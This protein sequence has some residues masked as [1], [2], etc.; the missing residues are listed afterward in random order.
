MPQL[1]YQGHA[2]F[3]LTA[4]DGRVIYIDPYV[5]DGYD[6]PAS[7]IVVTH[8]H[9]DHNRVRLCARAA[10]CRVITSR[11]ALANGRHQ[12]FDIAG[13]DLEAVEAKN[14]LHSPKKCVGYIIRLDGVSLYHSGDTSTTAQMAQLASYQ[15]DYALLCGDGKINMGP[16]EAARCARLIGARHNIMMHNQPGHLFNLAKAQRWDA[17]NKLIVQPGQEIELEPAPDA[18]RFARSD[19]G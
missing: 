6:R 19:G 11:D 10:D 12:R 7:L 8:N 5:G 1:L 13:I 18:D 3:R 14:L 2:S 4:D 9:G 15:L 17:P 16:A